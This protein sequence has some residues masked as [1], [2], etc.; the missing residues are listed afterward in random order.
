[1]QV[2]GGC[3]R[4]DRYIREIVIPALHKVRDKRLKTLS[5]YPIVSNVLYFY[6]FLK[7]TPLNSLSSPGLF[8]ASI[9]FRTRYYRYEGIHASPD[10]SGEVYT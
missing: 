5:V 4:N 1:M 9:A 2:S 8:V 7:L 3:C 10:A 6:V